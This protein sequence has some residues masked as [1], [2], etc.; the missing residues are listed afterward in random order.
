LVSTFPRF[1]K[2]C[3]NLRNVSSNWKRRIA[4]CS[5]HKSFVN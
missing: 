4:L 1:Q 2:F 5:L 3:A